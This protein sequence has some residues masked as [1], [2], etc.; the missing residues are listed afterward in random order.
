[1]YV[2]LYLHVFLMHAILC[3]H[4]L[5]S[6]CAIL[7]LHT[8]VFRSVLTHVFIM[9]THSIKH[10]WTTQIKQ[11]NKKDER[12]RLLNEI[13]N[14]IK[15]GP[16]HHHHIISDH[17]TSH[18]TTLPYHPTTP[19]QSIPPHPITP[20]SYTLKVLKLNAWEESLEERVLA[21]RN[22]ELSTIKKFCYLAAVLTF[23]W[24]C[25]PFLVIPC[26]DDDVTTFY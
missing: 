20:P 6:L 19:H 12:I 26:C 18:H 1:M 15:V 23:S 4:I 16:Y 8:F 22:S 21:I 5:F 11:M 13:L 7:C 14:G 24:S 3:L 10:M 25:A 2:Y 9:H 17:T